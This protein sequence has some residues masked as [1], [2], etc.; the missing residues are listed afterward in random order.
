MKS[1]SVVIGLVALLGLAAAQGAAA[2]QKIV[3]E[4]NHSARVSLVSAAGSV[5]VGNPAIADVTV[6][7]SRTLYIIGRGF[8]RSSVTVT[9]GYGRT[10]FDGDVVVGT[11]VEGGVTV[12]KGLK[13]TTLICSRTCTEP[14][15][16]M[17]TS[18]NPPQT[19]TPVQ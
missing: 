2:A 12:F 11:P 9:D 4:K 7:D 1:K 18:N 16:G 14:T 19:V 15:E 17:D 3:V 6:V 5:I 8:G 13:A 10:I